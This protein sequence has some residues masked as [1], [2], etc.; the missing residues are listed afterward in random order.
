M[1]KN[2]N[3][4]ILALIAAAI[5]SS[6]FADE[7]AFVARP[8]LGVDLG[9]TKV[10]DEAQSIANSLV[11]AVGGAATVTQDTSA[12]AGRI[13]AGYK[14]TE[15]FDLEIAYLKTNNIGVSFSG[16]ASSG[17]AYVGSSN[18]TIGGFDYSALIRPSI[19]SGY[20][21][22]YFRFGGT[23]LETKTSATVNGY[24]V[25]QNT[26]GTGLQ[27]GIGYDSDISTGIKSR[28]AFTHY[29]KI[30]GVSGNYAN[31]FSVGIIKDF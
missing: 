30:S 24:S 19:S 17:T 21:N 13:F 31:V 18:I 15:N 10:K 3:Q 25:S 5:S 6:A 27:Y 7:G 1:S 16:V 14:V 4:L 2:Q 26:N 12:Y 9:Y 8:Y 29:D 22:L 23:N 11:S 20:N 28:I